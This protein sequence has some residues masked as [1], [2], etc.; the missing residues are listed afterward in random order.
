MQ[1][2][3]SHRLIVATTAVAVLTCLVPTANATKTVVSSLDELPRH[4]Y[5]LEFPASK[6]LT[7]DAAFAALA[8]ALRSDLEADLEQYEIRDAATLQ[9]YYTALHRLDWLAGDREQAMAWIERSRALEDK[10]AAR[11]MAGRVSAALLAARAEVGT[12]GS[13]EALRHAFRRHLQ[14]FIEA[15][16]WPVIQDSVEEAQGKAELISE[17]L[18]VGMVQSQVD[19]VVAASGEISGDLAR[20]LVGLRFTLETI[21]PVQEELIATY[22]AL[23]AANRVTKPDIWAEREVTL[24]ATSELEPVIVAVWDS[25]I[26]TSVFADRLW[27]NSAETPDG[28]DTDDNGYVDDLHGIAFDVHGRRTPEL[29]HPHGDRAGRVEQAMQFMK[30]Y[31]DLQAAVSSPEATALKRHLGSLE[32]REVEGFIEDMSFSTLYMHG[33]HVAGIV[34]DG[35]PFASLLGARISFDY[36]AIPRVLNPAIA[37]RHARS[38]ADTVAYFKAHGVRVVNMSW[39]WTLKEVESNLEANGVGATAEERAA[40]TREIF[41]ILRDGLY[42]AMKGAPEILF[43]TAAGNDDNDVEFDAVIPSSFDLPNLLTIGAVDRAGDPTSFTSSGRNVVVYAN[44]LEVS[45][46]VPGG[47]RMAASG[48]SMASPNVVNL[49][50]KLIALAPD[51]QPAETIELITAGGDT[52]PGGQLLMHP[53]RS[54]ELLAELRAAAG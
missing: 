14:G 21:L 28:A 3:A 6:L 33:T 49:A 11:L 42:E 48:T 1:P 50:A 45:S 13:D 5:A 44:G 35:N 18:V 51:L 4:S 26:D 32:P 2:V 17:N 7:D 22:S 24:D 27:R 10:E 43:V 30:G 29:L 36:H 23:V 53:K 47:E 25:G 19:P 20:R 8:D 52:G 31:L 40:R 15:L 12:D 38:Y 37:R 46:F 9:S 54:V 16:P 41:G 34:L 39:G